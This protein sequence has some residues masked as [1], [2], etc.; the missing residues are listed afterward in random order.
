M[1]VDMESVILEV[2]SALPP[3]K[4]VSSEAVAR[5]ADPENW[6]RLTGHVRG[7]AKGLARQGKIVILR[8]G[9]PADPEA[10][11]GVYRLRLPDAG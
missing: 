7:A 9:K 8:H 2:V 11:K 10:F 6:R 4:S 5:A 1:A 3:G